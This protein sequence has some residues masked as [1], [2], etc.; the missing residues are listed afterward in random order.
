MF[1]AQFQLVCIAAVV[2][3][4]PAMNGAQVRLH[5]LSV[6]ENDTYT[7]SGHL[8]KVFSHF[9]ATALGFTAESRERIH[10]FCD[11]VHFL[12]VLPLSSCNLLLG[13]DNLITVTDQGI[14]FLQQFPFTVHPLSGTPA[15]GQK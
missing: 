14:L 15:P 1:K 3:A 13:S 2:N 10:I 5:S 4:Q 9:H 11:D 7:L 6:V 8:W 12:Q